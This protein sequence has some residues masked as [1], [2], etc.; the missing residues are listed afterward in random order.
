MFYL[1]NIK[2]IFTK[3]V[4]GVV[5]VLLIFFIFNS[6]VTVNAED[7][8]ETPAY[9]PS[10]PSMSN[11]SYYAKITALEEKQKTNSE[12]ISDIKAK[13]NLNAVDKAEIQ[14]LTDEN[15]QLQQTIKG[16]TK[17]I[18]I[19]NKAATQASKT[20]EAEAEAEAR[21]NTAS[22]IETPD[23]VTLSKI[24]GIEKNSTDIKKYINWLYLLAISFGALLAVIKIALAGIK[25]M[26]SDV[27]TNKSEAKNDIWGALIGLGIIL[28]TVLALE[29]VYPN[30]TNLNILGNYKSISVPGKEIYLSTPTNGSTNPCEGEFRESL[31]TCL[32]KEECS[33]YNQP[34]TLKDYSECLTRVNI[35][36]EQTQQ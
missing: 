24:P 5:F 14:T 23:F 15:L 21:G 33:K 32:I 11:K 16:Y 36:S 10:G 6:S 12:K 28:L 26:M 34:N 22:K 30:L 29:M 7:S 20:A 4:V 27:V 31:K 25:Y 9:T 35:K 2:K 17:N 13:T 18:D 19:Q 1:F 3:I 8:T